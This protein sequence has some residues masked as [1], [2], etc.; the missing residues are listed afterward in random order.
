MYI[1]EYNHTYTCQ[2][3]FEVIHSML[4]KFFLIRIGTV[5]CLKVQS[6]YVF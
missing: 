5:V 1:N 4:F 3:Y 6:T 2:I